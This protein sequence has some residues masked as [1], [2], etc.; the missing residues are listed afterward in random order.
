LSFPL[1]IGV[2]GS[3]YGQSHEEAVELQVPQGIIKGTMVLPETAKA[4]PVVLII[5]GSGPTDRNGNSPKGVTANYL[6]MLAYDMAQQGIASV[7]Y[8]KRGIGESFKQSEASLRFSDYIQDAGAWVNQLRQDARFSSVFVVGHSEGA[9]IGTVVAQQQAVSG[10][11]SLAGPGYPLQSIL[12][13]QISERQ[14]QFYNA[15]AD[16]IAKLE[17]GTPVEVTDPALHSLFRSSVQPYLISEFR[18]NPG[19]EIGK[20]KVPILL[21]QGTRDLQIQVSDAQSLQHANPEARLVVIGG[22][23]H[24]L[25]SVP[26]NIQANFAAYGD[27]TLPLAEKLIPAVT[28]FI[29]RTSINAAPQG[30]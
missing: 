12:L 5:A 11:V 25:K 26:D 14:P 9:L 29:K 13:R 7:R 6:K 16:I 21:I 2:S 23:N 28:E 17:Q 3:V 8:D 4:C 22:M 10:L 24:V 27:P 1:L 30:E 20:V 18:Y 19:S 15:C